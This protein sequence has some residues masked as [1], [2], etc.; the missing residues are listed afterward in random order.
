MENVLFLLGIM[1]EKM[2]L[3]IKRNLFVVEKEMCVGNWCVFVW[4][5]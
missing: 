5:H 1:G 2:S 3:E 4:R